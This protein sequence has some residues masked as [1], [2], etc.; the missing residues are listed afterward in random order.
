MRVRQ[1]ETTTK[2]AAHASFFAVE[3]SYG[4]GILLNYGNALHSISSAGKK[5]FKRWLKATTKNS[6]GGCRISLSS[7]PRKPAGLLF[8]RDARSRMTTV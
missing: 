8:K 3:F 4:S 2:N 5:T 6:Q 7:E 1:A